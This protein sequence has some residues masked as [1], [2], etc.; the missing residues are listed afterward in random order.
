MVHGKQFIRSSPLRELVQTI[1]G[2]INVIVMVRIY[3]LSPPPS[4]IY[5]INE[6]RK[7]PTNLLNVKGRLNV[8][9]PAPPKIV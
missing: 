3:P 2:K 9:D 1:T 6:L 5:I 7:V 8:K 4:H